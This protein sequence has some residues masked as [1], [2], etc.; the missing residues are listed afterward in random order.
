MRTELLTQ[1]LADPGWHGPHG[2]GPGALIGL[3][4]L[5]L[6]A[7]LVATVVWLATRG[8]RRER[9]GTDRAKDV[10]AERYARGEISSDEYTERLNNLG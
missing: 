9:S 5:L 6:I 3:I 8:A 1:W 10:L 4:V 7:A 2:G